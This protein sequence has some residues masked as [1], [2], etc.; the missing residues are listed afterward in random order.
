MGGGISELEKKEAWTREKGSNQRGFGAA[1]DKY[2][3]CRLRA[4]SQNKIGNLGE[5][6]TSPVL[7]SFKRTGKK[8]GAQNSEF[9]LEIEL[10]SVLHICECRWS[11]FL[12]IKH[13]NK[14]L[15]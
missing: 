15:S 4:A 2:V 14:H 8:F 11:L 3:E 12:I 10:Q 13:K 5:K 7:F 1:V 9:L 6:N